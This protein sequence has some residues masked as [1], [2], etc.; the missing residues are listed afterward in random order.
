MAEVSLIKQAISH[1]CN[2]QERC[3]SE[4]RYKLV[5]LGARGAE[6]EQV[7]SELIEAG[8]LNEERFARSYVRG[9]YRNNRWGRKKIIQA[10][11]Q[12]QVS[13]YCIRQ[14]LKEIDEDEYM[15]SIHQ[16]AIKKFKELRTERHAGIRKQKVLRYLLQKGFEYELSNEAISNI[17]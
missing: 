5:E 15:N 2:Y 16:L 8:L 14:G 12:K 6:L 3:H 4:V 9:K 10:L 1:Y 17:F 13:E 11:M 7:L